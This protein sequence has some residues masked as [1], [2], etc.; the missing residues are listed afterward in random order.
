MPTKIS[1][2][3]PYGVVVMDA[4][5]ALCS[6][7]EHGRSDGDNLLLIFDT[8]GFTFV[9]VRRLRKTPP[10]KWDFTKNKTTKVIRAFDYWVIRK[11]RQSP[12]FLMY[13]SLPFRDCRR[14][15]NCNEYFGLV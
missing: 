3:G 10:R 5:V 7:L 13:G 6:H 9:V 12:S 1:G 2:N 14:F 4:M 11:I 15:I 8:G